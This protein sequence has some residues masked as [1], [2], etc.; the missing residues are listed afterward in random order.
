MAARRRL[1]AGVGLP[2]AV[3]AKVPND[4]TLN[5]AVLEL[6]IAREPFTVSVKFCTADPLPLLAVNVSA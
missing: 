3:T 6:V 2:T 4:P 5:V 1:S